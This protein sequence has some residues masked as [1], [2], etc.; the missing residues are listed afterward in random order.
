MALYMLKFKSGNA[1]LCMG[2]REEAGKVSPE[3][4]ISGVPTQPPDEQPPPFLLR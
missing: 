3:A 2:N 4:G 1:D